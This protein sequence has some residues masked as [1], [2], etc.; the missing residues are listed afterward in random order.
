MIFMIK[1]ASIF[2]IFMIFIMKKPRALQ[3][4]LLQV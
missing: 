4:L 3:P 2:M 1:V